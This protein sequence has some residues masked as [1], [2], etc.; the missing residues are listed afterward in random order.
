MITT[1]TVAIASPAAAAVAT[2]RVFKL[3]NEYVHT[4]GQP[5]E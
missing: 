3:Q 5:C 4:N 1:F 2:N